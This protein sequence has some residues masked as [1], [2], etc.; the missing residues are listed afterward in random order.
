MRGGIDRDQ[1]TPAAYPDALTCNRC[2]LCLSVCPTYQ[3][4]WVETSSPRGRLNLLRAWQRGGLAMTPNLYEQI[5]RCLGC[6]A[7]TEICPGGVAV[8]RLIFQ[9]RAKM[10]R[11]GLVAGLRR[12]IISSLSLTSLR[13]RLAVWLLR[14]YQRLG[15]PAL[16]RKTP[17]HR[18]LPAGIASAERALPDIGRRPL[19]E[20]LPEVLE[21]QG[22]WRGRVGYFIGCAQN[23]LLPDVGEATARVL[24]HL[25]YDV[26]MPRGTVCCGMPALGYGEVDIW[27]GLARHN[28][29]QFTGVDAIITDCATC[30]HAL[31]EYGAGLAA[32]DAGAADFSARVRDIN[33]FL[34]GQGPL[35]LKQRLEGTVTY[36]DP[37]HLGRGQ[38]IRS[39]P[40]ELLR[41]I[42]GLG[43]VELPEA[44][45]CCGG[46]GSYLVTHPELSQA[47][48]RR[49]MENIRATGADTVATSCPG[50][51][52]QLRLG[53]ALFAPGLRVV[54]P[55]QLVAESMGLI[56][57]GV[58]TNRS[59]GVIIR[60]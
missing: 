49:K 22:E 32:D 11:R 2:G 55:V 58:L 3:E 27:R 7:C 5:Y 51:L 40:R 45:R 21:H 54:Y 33:E 29:G 57:G 47:I 10:K 18:W 50:C 46:G 20:R 16:V 9:S 15:L 48:L 37:C 42:P 56:P 36:H 53:V 60:P 31:R 13:L 19:R 43:Y 38:G 59:P 23:F 28:I 35:P 30:G 12:A 8:D 17:L 26:V 6:Q 1:A 25:G 24:Q 44:D 14:G 4:E 41:A 34:V 39:A 52:L